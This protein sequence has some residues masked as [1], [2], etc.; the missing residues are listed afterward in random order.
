[1][2]RSVPMPV[3]G[4]LLNLDPRFATSEPPAACRT[5]ALN[6]SKYATNSRSHVTGAL[7]ITGGSSWALA[8]HST[9][10]CLGEPPRN[11][12]TR[13]GSPVLVSHD[14]PPRFDLFAPHQDPLD[15]DDLLPAVLVW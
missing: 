2:Y 6:C 3:I 15:G 4:S 10:R 1:M 5:I 12:L 7:S 13:G 11:G 14:S 9:R 8:R